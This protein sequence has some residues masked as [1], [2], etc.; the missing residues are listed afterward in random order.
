MRQVVMDDW[1]ESQSQES[2]NASDD[3]RRESWTVWMPK[4][5]N[6]GLSVH[7]ECVVVSPDG[8]IRSG[9]ARLVWSGIFSNIRIFI[10][11]RLLR[12]VCL[13]SAFVQR[14]LSNL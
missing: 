11:A 8:W 1:R 2:Q 5:I 13:L 4:C 10:A 6:I 7:R 3:S 12:F 14:S 9:M